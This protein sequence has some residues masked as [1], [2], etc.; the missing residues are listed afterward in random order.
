MIDIS[1][2]FDGTFSGTP[3]APVGAAITATRVSTNVL[4]MLVARDMGAGAILG[5]HVD[6]LEAFATLTSLIIS[7]EVSADDST[8]VEILRSPTI[9][10]AQLIIGAPIFR[11]GMP[12]N[13]VLNATAGVLA[14][15]GRYIRLNYTV[16][17]S[18]ATAGE[19][20]SYLNPIN[21]RDQTYTYPRNYTAP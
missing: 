1:Q 21:D 4:D 5:I 2:I 18:N 13:Q 15:P 17:G 8:F 12:L 6:V 10:V 20:F 19:V 9:P 3:P 14:A 7:V 11:Y 16:G